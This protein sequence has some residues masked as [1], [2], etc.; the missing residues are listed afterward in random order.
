MRCDLEEL[1]EQVEKLKNAV[2]ALTVG[3]HP[4]QER[5][6]RSLS[7]F[8]RTFREPPEGDALPH[9]TAVYTAIGNPPIGTTLHVRYDQLSDAE[10]QAIET[11]LVE[12]QRIMTG[13][14][15]AASR[16]AS[17]A[18]PP[19]EESAIP[20]GPLESLVVSAG[21]LRQRS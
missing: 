1:E 21:A 16:A 18:P 17:Q 20:E 6:D 19:G 2:R 15:E 5:L 3:D 4:P 13:R 11:A 14:W 8:V 12:L 10:R 9:F 7:F